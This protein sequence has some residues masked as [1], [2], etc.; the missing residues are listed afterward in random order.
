MKQKYQHLMNNIPNNFITRWFIRK[1]NKKMRDSNSRYRLQARYRKPLPG[2]RYSSHG[3]LIP[4]IW[5]DTKGR[6]IN[7]K[8][9]PIYK[10]AK[11]FSVYLRVR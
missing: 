2:F 3:D 10:R 9:V 7:L 1:A 8:N 6:H 11:A 4:K 5:E